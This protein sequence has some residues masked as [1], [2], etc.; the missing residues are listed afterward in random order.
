MATEHILFIVPP[1]VGYESFIK[2]AFNDGTMAKGSKKYRNIVADV[3]IGL[4]SMSSYIKKHSTAQ[5]RLIDFNIVLHKAK[6]FDYGSFAEMFRDVLSA[7]EWA[8]YDPTIIG[9][10]ALF[11][12]AYRNMLDIGT[13]VREL[14]PSSFIVAGGGVPTNMHKEIFAECESFD[15]L[16][17]GE[18]EKPFLG[19]IESRDRGKFLNDHFAWITRD[20]IKKGLAFAFNFVVDLDEIPFLDY[21]LVNLDDYKINSI[22][23]TYP[24][25]KDKMLSVPVM[26]SRGCTHHCIFCSSHTVHGRV[27][28]YYGIDRVREDFR[29]LKEIYGT[30]TIVLF[31]DHFMADRQRFF[32]LV[33]VMNELDLTAFFPSSLALYALDRKVLEALKSIGLNQIVLSIESGSNR[34]LKDVMKKPLNLAIVS[35]VIRDCRELGIDTDA[36]ILIGLPGETKQDIEDAR[37][38]LKTIDATWFRINIATPLV[39]SEMLAICMEKKYLKGEYIDCDYKR[40]IVGTEEFTPEWLQE[41]VYAMNL[42]LNFVCNSD[43]RLGNYAKALQGIENAIRVK[44]DHALAYYYASLCHEKLGEAEQAATYFATARAIVARDEFWR[45]YADMFNIP[46]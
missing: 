32:D 14:F 24:F 45:H 27:M 40:A 31:D 26:T 35:R 7:K 46:L 28:R 21:E 42:E 38:F 11:T 23:A 8:D 9:V 18:G 25:A 6:Q 30:K 5:V 3:P 15:A 20:K 10:S 4:L 22:L 36:N 41:K 13:V 2:P 34:V 17:Y 33:N 16:C 1:Y 37:V 19:L 43:M 39:G 44:Q 29:R 12:P